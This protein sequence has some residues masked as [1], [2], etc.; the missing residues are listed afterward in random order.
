MS[1]FGRYGTSKCRKRSETFIK[2]PFRRTSALAASAIAGG[3][4]IVSRTHRFLLVFAFIVPALRLLACRV[5]IRITMPVII[6]TVK[7]V[8]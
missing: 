7:R 8:C 5:I 6:L 1:P 2:A 4:E 3:S